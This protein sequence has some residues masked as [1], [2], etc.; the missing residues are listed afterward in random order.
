VVRYSAKLDAQGNPVKGAD[1]HFVKDK[2]LGFNAMEKRTGWGTDYPDNI[3][4]GEWE[5]RAFTAEKMPN[6]NA[7]LTVCFEC[8]K[9]LASHDFVQSYDTLQTAKH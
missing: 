9:P 8:H 1:G 3:R 2:V 7:K 5:Y 6:E 4:N